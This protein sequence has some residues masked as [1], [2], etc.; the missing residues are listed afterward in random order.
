MQRILEEEPRRPRK[1]V[2]SV[3]RDLEAIVLKAIAKEPARRY[4]SAARARED[5]KRFA[6]GEPIGP[7]SSGAVDRLSKWARRRPAAAALSAL[8]LLIVAPRSPAACGTAVRLEEGKASSH[9]PTSKRPW[10]RWTGSSA[11]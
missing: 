5:L 7:L 8:A 3:P 6:S 2:A 4:E 9:R 1:T 11:W 10:S